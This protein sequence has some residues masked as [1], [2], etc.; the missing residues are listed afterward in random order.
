[1]PFL[2]LFAYGVFFSIIVCSA[3][4]DEK[5][6]PEKKTLSLRKAPPAAARKR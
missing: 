1:M 3:R 4:G 2:K 5:H 6:E